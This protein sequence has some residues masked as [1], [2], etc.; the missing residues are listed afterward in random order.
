[1]K[2]HYMIASFIIL[3]IYQTACAAENR[4]TVIEPNSVSSC[5]Y[6]GTIEGPS[7]YRMVGAPPVTGNFKTQAMAKASK[8]G[9]THISWAQQENLLSET[10][11]ANVYNCNN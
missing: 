1:M 7:G 6:I 10:I 9:A 11:V 2:L 4:I 3:L 8:M 5:S